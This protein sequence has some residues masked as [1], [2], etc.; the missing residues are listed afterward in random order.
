MVCGVWCVVCG[1]RVCVWCV[2][3]GVRVRVCTCA[4][5]CVCVCVCVCECVCVCAVRN[6]DFSN[7]P[8]RHRQV[9]EI[10]LSMVDFVCLFFP[11]SSP[12]NAKRCVR[13]LPA[14]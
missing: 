7:A 3:C 12:R 4:C 5:V 2:V 9:I 11:G 14:L 10:I 8:R 6:Q 1:A 13:G